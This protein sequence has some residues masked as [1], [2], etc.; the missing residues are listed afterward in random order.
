[1]RRRAAALTVLL[2][3][4]ALVVA[5]LL[6]STATAAGATEVA[7]G[8]VTLSVDSMSPE[9][10][11]SDQDLTITGT[12]VNGTGQTVTS[13]TL[14]V[15]VQAATEVTVKALSS[16]LAGERDT[17]VLT[18]ATQEL[19]GP[20]PPGGTAGFTV[21][22][23][24]D[25]L[26]FS[27]TSQWGPRGVEVSLGSG[28][29]STASHRSLVVWSD[30]ATGDPT[31]VTAVVPVTASTEELALVTGPTAAASDATAT[32]TPAAGASASAAGDDALEALRERV[33]GLLGLA[34]T[35]VV[36]AVDPALLEGLGVDLGSGGSTGSDGVGATPAAAPTPQPTTSPTA[37]GTAQENGAAGSGGVE[38]S[39]ALTEL[40]SALQD[41]LATG[42]VIA[43]PWR[44]VDVAALAHLGRTDVVSTAFERSAQATTL[45]AA[46]TDVAWPA[47]HSLDSDTLDALPETTSLVIAPT[48]SMEV[49]EPLTYT[50]SGVTTVGS[51]TVLLPDAGLSQALDGTMETTDVDTGTTGSVPLSDLDARQLLRAQTAIIAR[52]LPNQGRD[53]VVTLGREAADS[54]TAAVLDKRLGALLDSTWTSGADLATL[55]SGGADDLERSPLPAAVVESDEVSQADL[56][57]AVEVRQHLDAV[58]AVLSDVPAVLGDVN[59]LDFTAAASA[60]RTDPEG[61]SSFLDSAAARTQV[62]VDAL[63][64]APSSTV[65]VINSEAH[66]PVTVVNRLDQAVTV[67]VHLEPSSTRLQ[68]PEDVAVTV[69]PRGDTAVTLPVTAV[70]SGDVDVEVQILTPDG[71]SVVGTPSTVHMRVRADWETVGTTVVGAVLAIMLV[72]GIVRTVRRGRRTAVVGTDPGDRKGP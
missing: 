21:T 2:A 14:V 51:R 61:R 42:N 47:S 24:A 31:R 34:R 19:G 11:S 63:T 53:V 41:A 16:W 26:P 59:D 15:D 66:V 71:T 72:A 37:S 56:D 9:V 39:A 28:G 30:A 45:A 25:E 7:S 65:N 3:V 40:R 60:W 46:R 27:D 33:T 6:P 48:G 5:A 50:P 58:A 18:V 35:G 54:L 70:G 64:A 38:E 17:R 22:V 20:L 68:A 55:T 43:L 52:E 23:P 32:A 10:I 44:D 29:A 12:V 13:G 67:L 49:T 62:V 57:R 8:K 69:P 36:L 4:G 1:M